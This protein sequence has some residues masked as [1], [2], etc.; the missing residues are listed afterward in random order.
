M[1]MISI[2][3]LNLNQSNSNSI[4]INIDT[5][6][7]CQE[8]CLYSRVNTRTLYSTIVEA[9]NSFLMRSA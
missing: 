1:V 7:P 3:D 9:L 2:L 4:S 5:G 8:S 6:F